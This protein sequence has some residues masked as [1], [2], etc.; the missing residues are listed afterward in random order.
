M[1]SP[2]GHSLLQAS[3]CSSVGSLPR[4]VGG[5]LLHH[6]PPW[7]AGHSL[8]HYG[9][10]YELQGNLCYGTWSTSSPSSAQTLGSAEVL[11]SHSLTPLSC[12]CSLP[13]NY[14]I[15]EVLPPSLMGSALA[16]DGSV[17]EPAGVGSI[18][19]GGCFQQ[20]LTEATPVAP[21]LPKPCHTNPVQRQSLLIL[22]VRNAVFWS[23]EGC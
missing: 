3:T 20:L 10:H 15:P 1:G 2:R 17:L 4:D 5:D 13:L 21:L 14:F 18:R 23:M 16:S 22:N 6:G 19:Y 9:L 12:C 11:L 7:T 8:P